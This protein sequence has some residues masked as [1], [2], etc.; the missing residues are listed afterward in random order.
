[1]VPS[2][3]VLSAPL[4]FHASLMTENDCWR[5]G[6]TKNQRIPVKTTALSQL[7][8]PLARCL[9]LVRAM[10][11]VRFVVA[12]TLLSSQHAAVAYYLPGVNPM[13]FAEGES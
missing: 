1:M 7:S 5:F 11:F 8:F 6:A 4:A 2:W 12:C 9:W 13:S 10:S 3:L